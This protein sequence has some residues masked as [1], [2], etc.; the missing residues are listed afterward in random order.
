MK[1][2]R[3]RL[4]T[5]L[6]MMVA[7]SFLLQYFEFPIPALFPAYLKIDP[8]DIPALFVGIF[9][10]PGSAVIVEFLKNILHALF[11]SKDPN[12]SGEIANFFYYELN[13]KFHLHIISAEAEKEVRGC[14]R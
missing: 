3:L 10:G 9:V 6:S 14:W 7:L 5:L 8:S 11:I 2:H 1:N 4:L 13:A 12:F